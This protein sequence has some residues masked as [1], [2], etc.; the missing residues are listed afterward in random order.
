MKLTRKKLLGGFLILLALIIIGVFIL[1][2][3]SVKWL[4]KEISSTKMRL[5]QQGYTVSY[6]D[7]SITGNP[8]LMEIKFE[9]LSLKAP[10]EAWEWQG[11]GAVLSV[12]PWKPYVLT[13]SFSG[14]QKLTAPK[15]VPISLGTLSIEGA[16]GVFT[17]SSDGKL[18]QV[19]FKAKTISSLLGTKVQ[20]V[21]FK[22]L[23]L[24][25]TQL[26]HPLNSKFTFTTEVAN[27][28][29]LLKAASLDYSLTLNIEGELSGYTSK[30][31]F[32][33]SL[34][35]WRDGGGI[36]NI[37]S[38]NLSWLPINVEAE[39]TLTLDKNMYL[40]G[41]FSSKI[42]GYQEALKDMVKL[43][44]IKEKKALMASFVLELF[45]TT[46]G[47][48]SKQLTVPITF[49]NGMISVGPAPLIK[50]QPLEDI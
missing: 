47:V 42:T 18:E 11:K 15:N 19:D 41:S 2:E 40:L 21:S 35:E 5:E 32:P 48:G 17:L 6:S 50:L 30:T 44:W 46:D 16:L 4:E 13:C 37:I 20:A 9:N 49:Q 3:Y 1:F 25:M 43:G 24:N 31:S 34:S 39:G 12:Y 33:R 10:Q 8:L 38:L 27:L 22:N 45:T 14:D 29:S 28:E 7:V 26:S 36:M 23:S